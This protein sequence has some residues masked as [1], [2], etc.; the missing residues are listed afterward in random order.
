MNRNDFLNTLD[1]SLGNIS[2]MDRSDILYDYQEHFTIGLSEGKT[3]EEI[4][5]ELGDPKSIAKQYR[6]DYIVK[7]ADENKSAGNILRAIFAALSLGFFN[8][9]IM[10][11]IFGVLIAVLA[12][13]YACAIAI[14]ASGVGI[15]LGTL[16]QPV[17]P[18]LV[19]IPSINE[20]IL[21]FSSFG[22]TALGLLFVI[23]DAYVTK[24]FYFITMKYIKANIKIIAK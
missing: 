16:L 3:E 5:G 21:I 20:G 12:S 10:L 14:T 23:G 6:V 7:Q 18:Q 22:L 24:F 9:V 4:C 17:L 8:L 15:F 13:L 2:A 1:R 19:N 11:P